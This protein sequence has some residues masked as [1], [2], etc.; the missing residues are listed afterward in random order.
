MRDSFVTDGHPGEAADPV[1]LVRPV[2]VGNLGDRRR[3]ARR[4]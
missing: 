1:I 3:Y 2:D 4:R